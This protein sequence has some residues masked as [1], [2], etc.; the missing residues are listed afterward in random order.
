MNGSRLTFVGCNLV[1]EDLLR[2]SPLQEK[3]H[4]IL[5]EMW[6][7]EKRRVCSFVAKR[8]RACM[9]T[10]ARH[11]EG[12]ISARFPLTMAT[13]ETKRLSMLNKVAIVLMSGIL[14]LLMACEQGRAQKQTAASPQPTA[15]ASVRRLSAILATVNGVPITAL[16]VELRLKKAG[17]DE[18]KDSRTAAEKKAVLETIVREELAAQKAAK[19]GLSGDA[20]YHKTLEQ[21]QVEMAAFKR[22]VLSDLFFRQQIESKGAVSDAEAKKYFDSNRERVAT[23]LH[24]LQIL[25]KRNRKAAKAALQELRDGASFEDL[26]KKRF[27]TLADG[28]KPWDLGYLKWNQVPQPWWGTVSKLKKGEVSGLISDNTGRTWIVK[29]VDKR[30]NPKASFGEMKPRIKALLKKKKVAELREQTSKA[31]RQGATVVYG[32]PPDKAAPASPHGR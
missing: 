20:R 25:H 26:A 23:E 6:L 2:A 13:K 32:K 3:G 14:W 5:A 29:V 17:H 24:I 30:Q 1:G 15:T 21:M 28:S 27:P 31:L 18:G 10:R 16:D 12:A 4:P 11:F 22:Q 19:L 9:S 8:R 7:T